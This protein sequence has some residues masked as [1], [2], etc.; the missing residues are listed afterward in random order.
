MVGFAEAQGVASVFDRQVVC[1]SITTFAEVLQRYEELRAERYSEGHPFMLIEANDRR[2]A[3][4]DDYVR[5]RICAERKTRGMNQATLAQMMGMSESTLK[6]RLRRPST[7]TN[8]EARRLCDVFG[9]TV[10]YL[11]GDTDLTIP[12]SG[13]LKPDHMRALYEHH[14]TDEQRELVSN[15]VIQCVRANKLQDEHKRLLEAVTAENVET[16]RTTVT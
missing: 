3:M 5:K 13:E 7:F 2:Q 1:A 6:R 9:T 12:E 16:A 15:I 11:R 14:L 8:D 10:D 4:V